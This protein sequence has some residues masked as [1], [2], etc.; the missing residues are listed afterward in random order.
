MPGQKWGRADNFRYTC[1]FIWLDA[2]L[3]V[4]DR[5]VDARVDCMIDAGLL[6]EVCDMY[7]PKS[8]YTRGLKQ[9]IGVREFEEFF[10]AYSLDVPKPNFA[11]I[12]R[13]EDGE[14]RTLLVEA[15]DKFKANTRKLV[16]RQVTLLHLISAC[17]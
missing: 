6:N 7:K 8:D 15:I 10:K 13:S 12:L 1:C 17:S 16:R 14:L 11:D 5:Y 4:L 9:A 3:S 2:S